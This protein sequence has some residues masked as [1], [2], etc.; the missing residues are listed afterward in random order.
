VAKKAQND[1][2]V[3]SQLVSMMHWQQAKQ[4]MIKTRDFYS[5]QHL[6]IA[7]NWQHGNC[8]LHDLS[9]HSIGAYMTKTKICLNN[10]LIPNASITATTT[11]NAVSF[12]NMFHK[13]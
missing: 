5:S 4:R 9:F 7:E 2:R 1:Q 11:V 6:V 12:T 10:L 8:K 13:H 3:L